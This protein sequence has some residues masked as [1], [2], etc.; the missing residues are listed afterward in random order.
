VKKD[1]ESKVT[2]LVSVAEI[3]LK[4]SVWKLEL[5]GAVCNL[6]MSIYNNYITQDKYVTICI[7]YGMIYNYM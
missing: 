7:R 2:R 4:V 3:Y 6:E 1:T 5:S